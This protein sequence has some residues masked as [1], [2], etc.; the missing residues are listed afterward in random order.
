VG[1][2]GGG[3]LVEGGGSPRRFAFSARLQNW[4]MQK[5]TPELLV[6]EFEPLWEGIGHARAA[7]A[8]FAQSPQV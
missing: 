2:D 5:E 1:I 4:I 7:T 6:S 3:M 8:G